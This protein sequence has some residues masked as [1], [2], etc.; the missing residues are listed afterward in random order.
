MVS[1]CCYSPDELAAIEEVD[2]QLH[3]DNPVSRD[4]TLH[5]FT[6][7]SKGKG[8]QRRNWKEVELVKYRDSGYRS[9]HRFPWDTV[10]TEALEEYAANRGGHD[11]ER[12]LMKQVREHAKRD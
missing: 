1:R 12:E 3:R 6:S 8:R 4:F 10:S 9:W 11:A 5:S 7:R 2:R